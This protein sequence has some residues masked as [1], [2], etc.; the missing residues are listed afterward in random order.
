MDLDIESR[1]KQEDVALF[2]LR[3]VIGQFS[4]SFAE[5][6]LE[7][8]YP[9]QVI[10]RIILK[11][12]LG[13][14]YPFFDIVSSSSTDMQLSFMYGKVT[15][16]L[17]T[18]KEC[19]ICHHKMNTTEKP[20]EY[21]YNN[22]KFR[23]ERDEVGEVKNFVGSRSQESDHPTETRI[24]IALCSDCQEKI[25]YNYYFCLKRIIN[26]G[27]KN[28]NHIQKVDCDKSRKITNS[29]N[30]IEENNIISENRIICNN[31]LSPSCGF[32][33]NSERTNPCLKNHAFGISILK[34]NAMKMFVAPIESVKYK[35]IRTGGI[36]GVIIGYSDRI[37]NLE[38]VKE[39][40][41]RFI[42]VLKQGETLNGKNGNKSSLTKN[43]NSSLKK[44]QIR[45]L[46]IDS[47]PLEPCKE[48]SQ[49][50]IYEPFENLDP[51]QKYDLAYYLFA[52]HFFMYYKEPKIQSYIKSILER[53]SVPLK[54]IL[55][56][57]INSFDFEILDFLEL[58]FS[59][60]PVDRNFRNNIENEIIKDL[61]LDSNLD[62][63]LAKKLKISTAFQESLGDII[64]KEEDSKDIL[65]MFDKIIKVIKTYIPFYDSMQ[66]NNTDNLKVNEI[67]CSF[68]TYLIARSNLTRTP[69]LIDAEDLIGR[70]M[71]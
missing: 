51:A 50:K 23:Q 69:I 62:S 34:G 65:T 60:P 20:S 38:R 66:L 25:Y 41:P 71:V 22:Q 3:D 15:F 19:V 37:M 43:E 52:L 36:C 61:D 35:M 12:V 49:T 44:Q 53:T 68:G 14:W 24:P 47:E 56:R 6:T 67:L 48:Y 8:I 64:N 57:V 55:E 28:S 16:S 13:R 17:S 31:L 21:N 30:S 39:I 11:P 26:Q 32:P 5:S 58:I 45:Q 29:T 54:N 46:V 7:I 4:D 40:Y 59:Y 70:K 2:N 1:L 33:I 42:N 27:T 63:D 10:K 9:E 18:E